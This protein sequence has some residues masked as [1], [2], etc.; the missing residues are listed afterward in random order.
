MKLEKLIKLHIIL[1]LAE[2]EYAKKE[3]D[4]AYRLLVD[5]RALQK[6]IEAMGD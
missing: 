1:V 5:A 4:M 2:E 3:Y 6:E